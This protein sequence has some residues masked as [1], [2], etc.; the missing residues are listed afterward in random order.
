MSKS[1]TSELWN[2]VAECV[3]L[4]YWIYFKPYTFER[5]LRDIHPELK[6]R[7]NPFDKKSEFQSNP[8]LRRYAGQVWWLVALA[9]IFSLLF[10]ASF[11]TI[12][13]GESFNWLFSGL[14]VLLG[15][16]IGQILNRIVNRNKFKIILLFALLI[17]VADRFSSPVVLDPKNCFFSGIM[18]SLSF[19]LAGYVLEDVMFYGVD[20]IM[21]GVIFSVIIGVVFSV[22]GGIAG[23][24][25][26]GVA[27][28]V[29]LGLLFSA[30]M[31]SNDVVVVKDVAQ[32]VAVGVMGS[33]LF[34]GVGI[35]PG[36][37]LVLS[38]LRLCF[39]LPELIWVFIL[40]FISRFQKKGHY[41][42][43]LPPHFDELIILPLPF[44]DKMIVETYQENPTAAREIV[45]YLITSTNQ[46]KVA[47]Q[48]I[49][50]ITID[51]L[52]QCRRLRDIEDIAYQLSWIPYPPPQ[53]LGTVLPQ[54]LEISQSVRASQEATTPYRR[55]EL[56]NPP[57]NALNE[58]KNIL[59][60]GKNASLATK[61]G[62]ISDRWLTI[63][64]LAQRTLEETAK[65]SQEIRQVYIAGNSLDPETAKFR[66][67]GRIDIF[68]EIETLTLSDQPPVLLLYGGR[69][70]G[71]TSALKYLPYKVTSDIIPLLIDVQ[72]AASATTIKGFAENLAQQIIDS[73]RRLPRRLNLPYPDS[74]K[75]NED[76]FPALQTWL[77]EIERSH[78]SKRFLLCLDEFERLSEV[79][80]ATD[81][82]APLNFI[83]HLLQHQKQWIL[84]FSGSHQ[85]SEL[86][87]YWSDYLINTRALRMTYLQE[88]EARELI[89]Q[90]IED[91]TN[92]Y[93]PEAV[94]KIIQ[95]TRCQPYLVQLLCY[96]LVE[97][98]NRDIRANR[99]QPNTAKATLADVQEIIPIALE[100]GDQYFRELWTSLEESDRHLLTRLIAGETPTPQDSKLV[101]KLARKEILTPEGNTFQVPLVQQYIE[102][103]LE[104][105]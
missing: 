45:D 52:N 90:P 72:G 56:L 32:A 22:P 42:E 79:V 95:T 11:Y 33:L 17:L 3:R 44:M 13:S 99:R 86:D 20:T 63:L 57:I 62:S 64:Q 48:A 55:Y 96:E 101:K 88:S 53:E 76:P 84:L 50:K 51:I 26:G 75:L 80:K 69:R 23:S 59:A 21:I 60:F 47:R 25:A 83:R 10:I 18:V 104:E 46:Q 102:Q 103:L 2:Y 71:K 40:F 34:G 9:P 74:K 68:R 65:Q 12:A 77:A 81:S 85:L 39:W 6:P 82:R 73:A 28:G 92:I 30:T 14:G 61:F 37:S 91:F 35:A 19:A 49:I 87:A 98:L 94:N 27:V 54:F 38:M 93:E 89:L 105:E 4:L 5:W 16:V 67:K 58:L 66:F 41:L 97:L 7:D 1:R 8:R 15:C 78:S 29:A 100:R 24:V 43:Y 70:T 31:G 36:L